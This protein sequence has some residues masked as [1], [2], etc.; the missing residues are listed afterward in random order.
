MDV[1]K[2]SRRRDPGLALEHQTRARLRSRHWL[3]LHVMLI[4]LL[5]LVGL[6]LGGALLRWVGF[7]ALAMR[8]ALLLPLT[9]LLYLGLLRLWARLLLQGESGDGA[10]DVADAA[11]DLADAPPARGFSSGAG[12]DFGGGGATGD[13]ADGAIEAGLNAGGKTLGAL[14][15]A[16]EGIVVAI[17]LAV[18]IGIASLLA[19][20][21]GVGV[22]ALF[23]VDVLLA[24]AVEVALA[25]LAGSFAYRRQRQGWFGAAVGHTWRGALLM[26][27]LGVALGW[28]IDHWLPAADSLPQALKLLLQR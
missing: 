9:Y 23:G 2:I 12:G 27:V 4:A 8:Y 25:A 7:E 21:L 15:D 16:D 3:R 5:T 28:L 10:F 6:W 13:F 26:L 1:N 17:P 20:L 14:A 18:V 19:A 11:L 22:V 24:V